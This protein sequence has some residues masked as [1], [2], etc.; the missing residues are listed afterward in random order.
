M[1][2]LIAQPPPP[3]GIGVLLTGLPL[4]IRHGIDWD[5]IAAITDITS[6]TAA[7]GAAEAAHAEQHRSVSGHQHGHGGPTELRAH[8]AGPGAATPGAGAARRTP[9]ASR[10]SVAAQV[11]AIGSGRCTRSVTASSSSPSASP[12]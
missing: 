1:L 2:D 5:H 10:G 4:G 11:E 8:D 6:T 7:A 12:P 3:A 9:V